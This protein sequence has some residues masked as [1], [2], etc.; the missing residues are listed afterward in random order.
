MG[1][2]PGEGRG[3]LGIVGLESRNRGLML[4]TEEENDYQS[5]ET[6]EDLV[7]IVRIDKTAEPLVRNDGG[8]SRR[9][10]G[11]LGY[12]LVEIQGSCYQ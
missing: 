4:P 11:E 9:G 12:C 1:T 7:K 6:A 2:I 3:N 8:N 10:K 5:S